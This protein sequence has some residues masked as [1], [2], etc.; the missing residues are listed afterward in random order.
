MIVTQTQRGDYY[1]HFIAEKMEAQRGWENQIIVTK[2]Q[3]GGFYLHF[4]EEGMEALRGWEN[5]FESHTCSAGADI[6]LLA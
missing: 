4:I 6:R 5:H 3:R 2:T 1:L